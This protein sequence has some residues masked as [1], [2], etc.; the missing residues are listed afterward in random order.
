MPA[1]KTSYERTTRFD[2]LCRDLKQC[3]DIANQSARSAA[4]E[5]VIIQLKPLAEQMSDDERVTCARW[6]WS[7][8]LDVPPFDRVFT[9]LTPP[10]KKR[11][12]AGGPKSVGV[13]QSPAGQKPAARSASR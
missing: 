7:A 2:H 10:V 4:I 5:A 1:V 6:L 8:Y 11:A 13:A 12:V 3:A 9:L